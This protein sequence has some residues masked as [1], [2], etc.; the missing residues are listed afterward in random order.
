M[1]NAGAAKYSE[2]SGNSS[3]RTWHVRSASPPRH[4]GGAVSSSSAGGKSKPENSSVCGPGRPE[5]GNSWRNDRNSWPSSPAAGNTGPA[6][7]RATKP[8][9]T[10]GKRPPGSAI[11]FSSGSHPRPEL[12]P[13]S[14]SLPETG[15]RY[16]SICN[17]SRTMTEKIRDGCGGFEFWG[18]PR[19]ENSQRPMVSRQK[20]LIPP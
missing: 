6:G 18:K 1:R 11:K 14:V 20:K 9:R 17:P 4:A 13:E 19:R 15:R 16:A 7:E 8:R 2:P 10:S 12:L 5:R 3:G